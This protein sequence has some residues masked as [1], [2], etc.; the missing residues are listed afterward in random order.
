MSLDYDL[1]H[2]ENLDEIQDPTNNIITEALIF[3][4][5]AI[6]IGEIDSV[7]IDEAFQRI[8]IWERIMGPM[9]HDGQGEPRPMTFSM[10]QRRIGLRT[11][12]AFQTRAKWSKK[13]MANLFEKAEFEMREQRRALAEL[14]ED[15][16]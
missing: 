7:T 16:P 14:M 3:L 4:T 8:R 13:I 1:T 12:V 10:V 15:A 9:V 6:D 2:V 5:M 11:N